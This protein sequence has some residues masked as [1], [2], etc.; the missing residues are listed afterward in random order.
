[1][2]FYL[3]YVTHI[4]LQ[5]ITPCDKSKLYLSRKTARD[6]KIVKVFIT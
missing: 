1:M 6:F 3:E 2:T 4:V 5:H